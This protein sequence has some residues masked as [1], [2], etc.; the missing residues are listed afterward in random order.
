[1]TLLRAFAVC[2]LLALW[3]AAAFPQEARVAAIPFTVDSNDMIRVPVM[4][5][6]SARSLIFDTGAGIDVLAPSLIA[7]LHG[8]PAGWLDAFRMT[9]ERLHI[10]LFRISRIAIGSF[11]ARDVIVGSADFLDQMGIPGIISLNE[12]RARAVTLDLTENVLTVESPLTL[13]A[14]RASGRV[15]SLRGDDLRG[16]S[17]DAFADFLIGGVRGQCVIDTGSQGPTV[18]TRYFAP[19]G[20]DSTGP[21]VRVRRST[22]IAGATQVRFVTDLPGVALAGAPEFARPPGRATFSDIIYDCVV[23]LDWWKGRIVTFDLAA[24]QLIVR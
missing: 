7:S 4:V 8:E 13:R 11:T 22:T 21:G 24:R 3:P 15:V 20:I 1:M 9:G 2:G 16:L 18:S 23:G 14:R 12:F 6:D 10:R 17:I 5:G 19:L